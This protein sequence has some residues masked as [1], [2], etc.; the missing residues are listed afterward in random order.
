M[1]TLF[2]SAP[3]ARSGNTNP[4][5]GTNGTGSDI[6]QPQ[7]TT[8]T[9]S[10]EL[11]RLFEISADPVAGMVI[12]SKTGSPTV[13]YIERET[14]HG[15]EFDLASGQKTRISNTTVTGIQEAFLNSDGSRVIDRYLAGAYTIKSFSLPIGASTTDRSYLDDNVSF[16]APS[17]DRK[18]IFFLESTDTGAAGFTAHFTGDARLQAFQSPLREWIPEWPSG[19]TVALTTK[20][21]ATAPG[22]LYF[23]ALDSGNLSRVLGGIPG[24]ATTVSRDLNHVFYAYAGG[25]GL[26]NASYITTTK[27]A[28]PLPV[29]TLPEKCVWSQY[30]SAFIY[31]GVPNSLPPIALPDGWYQGAVSFD[32]GLWYL[33]TD[34]GQATP[35]ASIQD[36]FA[37]KNFDIIFPQL[38]PYD[39]Y[40]IFINKNDNTLWGYRIYNQ[41]QVDAMKAAAQTVH[42]PIL[43]KT[44]PGKTP[45]KAISKAKRRDR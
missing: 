20:A 25:N 36:A 6:N 24:L 23:L 35:I 16:I 10:A 44:A 21:S 45:S 31:C 18:S 1:N 33:N 38:S 11:P 5:Q 2:P 32:D 7:T 9:T 28:I 37:G 29:A 13:R 42:T 39:Q 14:G 40:F 19:K 3:G 4:G 12:V 15:F 8:G 41:A 27:T 30:N 34:K 22:Y 43:K 26:A 17:P